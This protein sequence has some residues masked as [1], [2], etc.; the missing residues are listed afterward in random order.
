MVNS[1]L[2]IFILDN[3]KDTENLEDTLNLVSEESQI[4]VDIKKDNGRTL[5]KLPNGY[6]I[7]FLHLSQIELQEVSELRKKQSR[8]YFVG[9]SIMGVDISPEDISKV[10]DET[11][12]LFHSKYQIQ[13][14]L[15]NT[16]MRCSPKQPKS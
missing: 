8:S 5:R 14:I 12:N 11:I 3:H 10:F 4:P 7:Y 16:W 6:D 2:K 1:P 9:V 15:D 13:R